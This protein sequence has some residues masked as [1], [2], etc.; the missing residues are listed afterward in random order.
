MS[1][2]PVR[3]NVHTVIHPTTLG[4]LLRKMESDHAAPG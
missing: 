1:V 3:Q 2:S 4:K